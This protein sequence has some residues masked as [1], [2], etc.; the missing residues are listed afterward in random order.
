MLET[1][2]VHFL[3]G[4]RERAHQYRCDNCG[5]TF[6]RSLRR[7]PAKRNF[8][9]RECHAAAR[10][11]E[12]ESNWRGGGVSITCS[13]CGKAF[14]R[15]CHYLK[16]AGKRTFCSPECRSKAIRLYPDKHTMQLEMS[17]RYKARKRA[18]A[19]ILTHTH[20]EWTA[21]VE[22]LKHRCARCKKKRPLTRDHIIPLSKGGHDGITNI[23]PLC[24]PCNRKK[25]ATVETL[26]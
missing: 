6:L 13:T 2:T 25:S 18:G 4:T 1:A 23:Q 9:S 17:R 8:C 3:P 20:A 16:R 12:E 7:R 22:R 21:L 26:L 5:E 15:A 14:M 11:G 24:F 10:G 19:Q